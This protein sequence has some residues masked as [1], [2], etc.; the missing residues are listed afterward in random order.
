MAMLFGGMTARRRRRPPRHAHVIPPSTTATRH[1]LPVS[2]PLEDDAIKQQTTDADNGHVGANGEGDVPRRR[3]DALA[4]CDRLLAD[5]ARV[6]RDAR[7]ISERVRDEALSEVEAQTARLIDE[8]EQA[9]GAIIGDARRIRDEVLAET[10]TEAE[11]RLADAEAHAR[12]IRDRA[13]AAATAEAEREVERLD[14]EAETARGAR[15]Q[16]FRAE[17][18]RQRAAMLEVSAGQAEQLLADAAAAAEERKAQS[19]RE[20]TR[21]L[22]AA[23]EEGDRLKAAAIAEGHDE[24][25]RLLAETLASG[26]AEVDR[27]F[28]AAADERARLLEDAQ[29]EVRELV[30]Q[31]EADA[32]LVR[33]EATRWFAERAREATIEPPVSPAVPAPPV[34]APPVPAPPVPAPRTR[35]RRVMGEVLLLVLVPMMVAFFLKSYVAQAFYIPSASME[36]KLEEGDRVIVSKLAYRLESPGRGDVVV[37]HPP[38]P[39]P[40]DHAALP[41]RVLHE[42]LGAIGIREPGDDTFIKR[43]IGLPGEVVE[44]R[45]GKVFVDGRQLA[46]PWLQPTVVTSPF[47]PVRLGDDELFLMGDNR[48]DSSDSRV[49]GPVQRSRVVGEATTRAWPPPRAGFL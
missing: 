43:V 39:A 38:L 40:E 30:R 9:R 16:A 25:A 28:A 44:G 49:F 4:E 11:Q 2:P 14:A 45:D 17:L 8:A 10:D 48:P 47:S 24:A 12:A 21:A 7:A 20:A 6:M 22:I 27:L 19:E 36:P 26:R 3:E 1:P 33:A 32:L 37:F 35:G 46:E 42:I 18:E 5:A 23:R 29:R 31:A 15:E 13:V 41:F 34:P